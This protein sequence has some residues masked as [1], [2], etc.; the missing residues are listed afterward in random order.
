MRVF[1]LDGEVSHYWFFLEKLPILRSSARNRCS[2]VLLLDHCWALHAL[3]YRASVFHV[4][5]HNTMP[6]RFEFSSNHA[7]HHAQS[8]SDPQHEQYQ[9]SQRS[10]SYDLSTSSTLIF[11][12]CSTFRST[13]TTTTTQWMASQPQAQC[14]KDIHRSTGSKLSK[15]PSAPCTPTLRTPPLSSIS[16]TRPLVSGRRSIGTFPVRFLALSKLR[17][18]YSRPIATRR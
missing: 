15:T 16:A 11:S 3:L 1:L 5:F 17:G 2:F 13:H 12:S 4:H 14:P 7:P 8:R 9:S 10:L 6:I 18:T